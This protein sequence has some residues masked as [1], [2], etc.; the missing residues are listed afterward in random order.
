M[1]KWKDLYILPLCGYILANSQI[2]E[3]RLKMKLFETYGTARI[4][5]RVLRLF[6]VRSGWIEVPLY[7][8]W[9]VKNGK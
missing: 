4:W 1:E 2:K 9:S 6:R 5:Q 7:Q 3:T 8:N